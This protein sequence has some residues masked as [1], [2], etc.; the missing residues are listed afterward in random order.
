[1]LLIK[2][3]NVKWGDDTT[4]QFYALFHVGWDKHRVGVVVVTED[5]LVIER[6]MSDYYI[7]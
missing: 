2:E 4:R 1:M 5:V 3:R 6:G 7:E